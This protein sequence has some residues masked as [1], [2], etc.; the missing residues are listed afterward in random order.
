MSER[1][2]KSYDGDLMEKGKVI[3]TAVIEWLRGQGVSVIDVSNNEFMQSLDVDIVF[4]SKEL[5]TYLGEIK[6][7]YR[8]QETGNICYET[9]RIYHNIT[10]IEHGW[11][12]KSPADYLFY[13]SP[14]EGNLFIFKFA[15]LREIVTDYIKRTGKNVKTILVE[16]D[17]GKTTHNILIPLKELDGA[18]KLEEGVCNVL[19]AEN[20]A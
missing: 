16:T 9:M 14:P 5:K 8:M 1:Q 3:E 7:D 19:C 6:A 17:K 2:E 20:E 13:A 18:Y 15:K 4:T 11:G 12:V 10:R